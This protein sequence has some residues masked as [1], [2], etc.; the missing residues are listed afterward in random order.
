MMMMMMMT[1]IRYQQ[2]NQSVPDDVED[3]AVEK[4]A[5]GGEQTQWER[6]LFLVHLNLIK[7]SEP[8]KMSVCTTDDCNLEKFIIK[9]KL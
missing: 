6:L 4:A 5:D 7:D 1:T 3:E 9:T 8:Y 2:T